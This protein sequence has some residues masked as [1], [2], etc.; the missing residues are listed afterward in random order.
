MHGGFFPLLCR[1]G[2]DRQCRIGH[3]S[4]LLRHHHFALF[5]HVL[6]F[7]MR[8]PCCQRAVSMPDTTPAHDRFPYHSAV[9]R[10]IRNGTTKQKTHHNEIQNK[11]ESDGNKSV[12][13][14]CL[15]C[16]R[17]ESALFRAVVFP[18]RLRPGS[19]FRKSVLALFDFF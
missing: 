6:F 19:F 10:M 12:S 13:R 11:I 4:M 3:Q 7:I 8:L 18:V 9:C 17:I 2:M 15:R 1:H 5:C 14:E 16:I